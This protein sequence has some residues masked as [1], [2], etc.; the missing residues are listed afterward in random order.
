MPVFDR[1]FAND[2]SGKTWLQRLLSL[3]VG[4]HHV[5]LLNGLD[6]T[7]L[8]KGWG[9]NEKKLE[10]PVS[11]LS[12]LIRHP[13]NM[14]CQNLS[15]DPVKA[16]KRQELINGSLSQQRE[17]LKLLRNNPSGKGWHLFEGKTQPDLFR[18]TPDTLIV[19]EGKRTES[20]AT[21]KTKWMPGRHQMLRHIDCAWEIKGKKKVVGFFIVEGEG[22]N[23]EISE[24]WVE[25][26]RQT[27]ST[28]A[29]TSSF[30]HRGPE[31]QLAIVECFSGATTWQ[32]VC[33]EF[34]IDWQ[35]LP[36]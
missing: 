11:L 14:N 15:S 1:L 24:S 21:T 6:L 5:N 2:N 29:I 9:E 8:D 22:K 33:K 7:I 32:R 3:P 13:E 19:I 30:P 28:E 12:W 27:M 18:E 25:Q 26:V 36:H 4:G 10:P 20:G 16:Q 31:E 23:P 35:I 34:D 17:A